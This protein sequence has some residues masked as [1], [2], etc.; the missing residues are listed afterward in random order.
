MRIKGR[1]IVVTGASRGIGQSAA[2]ALGRAGARL[3]LLAR[4]P[5]VMRVAT[6]VVAAGG[7]ARGYCVDLTDPAAVEQIGRQIVQDLG[8]P[9]IIINNAGAGRYLSV[10]ETPLEEAASMVASPYLAAFYVTRVFLPSLLE[11]REGYIVNVN[12]PIAWLPWPGASAYM[13]ARWALRGF[14]A[15]L[16]T[17][18]HGTGIRVLELVPGKV[19]STYFEHNPNS[20]ERLPKVTQW[21]RTLTPDE[22]A[23]ALVEGIERDRREMVI[24]FMLH[25]AFILRAVAPGVV[26]G[27][28]RRTGWHR[29]RN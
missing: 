11:R 26:D 3:A 14:T 19:S 18:L 7:E 2:L 20:E 15:A 10:E 24:P 28:M 25:L 1:V 21:I 8:P 12:S 13:S 5:E 27:M 4:S 9:E 6:E 29:D 17:D 16:R 22:V 23:A